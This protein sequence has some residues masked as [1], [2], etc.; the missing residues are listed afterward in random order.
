M[1]IYHLS[2][3][4]K[5]DKSWFGFKR[6]F[7]DD[8]EMKYF[9]GKHVKGHYPTEDAD[10]LLTLYRVVKIDTLKC[11]RYEQLFPICSA[12]KLRDFGKLEMSEWERKCKNAIDGV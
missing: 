2:Y 4:E 10:R 6:F 1:I 12:K 3:V 8:I 7:T 5:G 11:Y 9:I